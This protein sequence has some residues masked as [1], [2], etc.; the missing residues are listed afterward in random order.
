MAN[1]NEFTSI[2]FNDCSNHDNIILGRKA[3]K[4]SF[5]SY[6]RTNIEDV[7]VT[8]NKN[9]EEQVAEFVIKK[10]KN[11]SRYVKVQITMDEYWERTI[12]IIQ[13][14]GIVNATSAKNLIDSCNL[15]FAYII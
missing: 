6:I 13:P 2:L 3:F 9:D 14:N 10:K 4:K 5:A 15:L 12:K 7:T 1:F 8:V 11:P